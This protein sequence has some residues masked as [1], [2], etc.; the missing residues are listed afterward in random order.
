[1]NEHRKIS[2]EYA[3]LYLQDIG[4]LGDTIA[5]FEGSFINCFGGIPGEKVIARIFRYRRRR[6]RFVSAIVSEVM[7]PS[8]HRVQAPCT[9]FGECTGCQWQHIE[10][11]YQLQLKK[12]S[13]TKEFNGFDSLASVKI[14]EVL[15]ALH[16][17]EYRNHARF[18]VRRNGQVGYVNR[19]TRR[20][21][22]VWNCMLMTPWINQALSKLQDIK[23]DTSQISV[24]YGINT[25][26]S[27][28]QP[29]IG[30][31]SIQSGQTHYRENLLGNIFRVGSPSFFQVNTVQAE[32]LAEVILSRIEFKG[33]EILIDAFA[34][35]GT[36]SIL[37]AKYVEKVVSIE[38]SPS[39][40]EDAKFNMSDIENIEIIQGK[41]EILLEEIDY[42][43]NIVILDPPRAGCHEKVLL[44]L[45]KCKAAK[46]VYVSCDPSTLARDL[47]ILIGGGFSIDF[48]DPVDMFPQTYH[49]ECVVTLSRSI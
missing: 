4:S 36:F 40:I 7:I 16:Q 30:N 45:V 14:S 19:I 35:V 20:F 34:G 15:P 48:V 27:L 31:E 23:P 26:D 10:Y 33:D 49:V 37:F 32:R 43:P 12:E 3:L 39:A 22:P 21:I 5:E 29:S 24:R 17:F 44:S 25:G 47:D 41:T 2:D 28:V 1:M 8:K 13:I 46:V 38:E 6:Q 42:A 11:E 9:Y 18:T